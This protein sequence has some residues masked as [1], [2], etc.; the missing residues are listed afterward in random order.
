PPAVSTYRASNGD[1]NNNLKVFCGLNEENIFLEF[2]QDIDFA[3]A[4]F[5]TPQI[6]IGVNSTSVQSGK[7]GRM[8]FGS[9]TISGDLKAHYLMPP[10]LG[11]N[12]VTSLESGGT[13]GTVTAYGTETYMLLSAQWQG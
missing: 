4:T 2:L 1:S 9:A 12:T 3:T 8:G 7:V 10:S 11:V 5:N 6:A 13:N